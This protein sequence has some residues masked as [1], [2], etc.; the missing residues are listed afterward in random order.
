MNGMR[1]RFG[2]QSRAQPRAPQ[3]GRGAQARAGYSWFRSSHN[4]A[5][6]SF[7]RAVSQV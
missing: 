7:D 2:V 6:V 1:E 3:G 5:A 4:A